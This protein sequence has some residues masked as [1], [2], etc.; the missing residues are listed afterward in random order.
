MTDIPYHIDNITDS[1]LLQ[2]AHLFLT[3]GLLVCSFILI[4]MKPY[5][6]FHVLLRSIHAQIVKVRLEML[7]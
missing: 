5:G 1:L 7:K 4:E 2:L 6:I 3:V